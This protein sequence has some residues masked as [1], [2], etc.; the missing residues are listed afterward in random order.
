VDRIK[1]KLAAEGVAWRAS[2]FD[3]FKTGDPNVTLTGI[4]TCFQPTFNVLRQAAAAK[5]NFVVSHE[6][7]FWDGFDPLDV[8]KDDP[9]AKAKIRFVAENKMAVWRIHD[10]WH[11]LRPEPMGRGLARK[12]GW[13]A[14]WTDNVR[15]RY[16]TIPEMS[17]GEMALHVQ[18]RL[19]TRNVVAVGEPSLRVRTVDDCA[20]ILSSVLGSLRKNDA[21]LV[22]ETPQHDTF[23]YMR[24]AVSLGQKKGIVMISHEGL[25]EWGMEAFAEW[26]RPGGSRSAGRVDFVGRPVL[27][28]AGAGIGRAACAEFSPVLYRPEKR[29]RVRFHMNKVFQS[30]EAAAADIP[31]GATVML[32]GF[33]RAHRSWKEERPE[34][35]HWNVGIAV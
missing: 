25:E 34:S 33:G 8:V 4:A 22:G 29:A 1:A 19:G 20:H 21:V 31:A 23:E 17:L 15:P 26:F 11:S 5:K 14:Y 16:F 30:F 28:P 24:D 18:Q 2:N 35:P 27:H 10:H 7:C 3:G 13:S 6:C 9:V 12:L 32:G